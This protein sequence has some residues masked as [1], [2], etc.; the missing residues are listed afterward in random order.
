MGEGGA[1]RRERGTLV[2]FLGGGRV[3]SPWRRWRLSLSRKGR[4]RLDYSYWQASQLSGFSSE[5]ATASTAVYSGF[6]ASAT[7]LTVA[8][9]IF[10]AGRERR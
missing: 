2:F 1:K 9:A 10:V 8:L 7:P 3:P 5:H 4:G 6:A